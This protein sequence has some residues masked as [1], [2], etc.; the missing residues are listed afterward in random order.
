MAPF[1]FLRIMR[2]YNRMNVAMDD[3]LDEL[4]SQQVRESHLAMH[5][6]VVQNMRYQPWDLGRKLRILRRAKAFVREHE[7]ALQQR[8]SESRAA[9]DVFARGQQLIAKV[10]K[11]SHSSDILYSFKILNFLLSRDGAVIEIVL[12]RCGQN[13]LFT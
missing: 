2:L 12:N 4:Q 5:K 11:V 13:W 8:L 9:K 10:K 6:E 7:G 3:P 1:F